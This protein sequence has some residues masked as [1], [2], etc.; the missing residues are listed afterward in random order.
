MPSKMNEWVTRTGRVMA[1]FPP[2]PVEVRCLDLAEEVGELARALL[3]AE[4]HKP[5]VGDEQPVAEA[6]C[7]VMFDVFALAAQ[8]HL[9]LDAHYGAQLAELGRRA[10]LRGKPNFPT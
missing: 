9:D 8:Y 4:N 6:L 7:G 2:W 10:P 1:D 5:A 3:V